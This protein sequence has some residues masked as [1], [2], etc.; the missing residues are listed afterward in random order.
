M[1]DIL[2]R[3]KSKESNEWVCGYL[4]QSQD[5][6]TK[7]VNYRA[8]FI[9]TACSIAKG[10][11]VDPK[12]VGQYTGLKDKNGT[13]IFE[14]DIISMMANDTANF[15]D[16]SNRKRWKTTVSFQFSCWYLNYGN[17]KYTNPCQ[18]LKDC[19]E[20]IEVIGNIHD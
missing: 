19:H 16:K 8:S 9:Y 3:G 4:W 13:K 11:E 10:H 18:Y 1:R 20:D 5:P 14:G 15:P 7:E 17:Y 12:T 6:C 2:F